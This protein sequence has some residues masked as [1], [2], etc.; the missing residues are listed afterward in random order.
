MIFVIFVFNVTQQ[1]YEIKNSMG[2]QNDCVAIENHIF[3]NWKEND[4]ISR[5]LGQKA[6][7]NLK[8]TNFWYYSVHI[9]KN[10][11]VLYGFNPSN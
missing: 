1:L 6:E 9:F 2:H 11:G 7:E 8:M 5:K 10:I 3:G 4:G